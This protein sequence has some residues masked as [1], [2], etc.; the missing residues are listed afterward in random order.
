MAAF[1]D[2]Y[3]LSQDATF[4]HRV[5]IAMLI[6]AAGVINQASPN[7]GQLATAQR[8]V[9]APEGFIADVSNL[10]VL[11]ATVAGTAPTGSGLTDAQLQTAVNA[12]LLQ[13]VR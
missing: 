7:S 12:A 2:Q 13:L 1:I 5:M 11:N 8:I 6:A 9:D 4:Q 10:A 3:T